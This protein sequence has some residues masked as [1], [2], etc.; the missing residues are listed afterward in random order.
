MDIGQWINGLVTLVVGL[1]AL[2]VYVLQR[3]S[4]KKSAAILLVMDIRHVERV[5][6][7]VLQRNS[8]D[9]FMGKVQGASNWETHK[10]LFASLLSTDDLV[11]FNKFFLACS[12]ISEA[13]S[14]MRAIFMSGLTAK[15][16]LIQERLCSLNPRE[17]DY[18]SKRNDIISLF[19][20]EAWTFDPDDPKERIVKSIQVMGR[21]THTEG[22]R[23]LKKIAGMDD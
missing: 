17:E 3:K 9:R 19:S 20:Q 16:T 14:D 23:K 15:S 13:R 1:V 10:H 6:T 8:F 21:L 7:E 12:E 11:S 2:L 4:E 5:I 22:F 18:Q